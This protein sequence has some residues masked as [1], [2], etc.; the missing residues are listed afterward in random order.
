M[1][2]SS[3]TQATITFFLKLNRLRSPTIIPRYI[4]SD[5]D[6]AQINACWDVYHSLILLCWWHVL[7]AWQQHFHISQNPE[8]W[9]LLKKWVRMTREDEFNAAWAEIQRIAPPKFV[10]YLKQ[11]WMPAHVVRMWS[12]VH[13]KDRTIFECCDTNMLIEA[14]VALCVP[15]P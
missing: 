11:Y 1:L 7:H 12:A 9:E 6:W 13:R 4:M 2:S 15:S 8:L 5:F 3:G 14:Y 10:V